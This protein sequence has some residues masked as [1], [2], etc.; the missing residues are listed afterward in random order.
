MFDPMEAENDQIIAPRKSVDIE[1]N[2]CE[3]AN[4][5]DCDVQVITRTWIV[6]FR[7]ISYGDNGKY[8]QTSYVVAIFKPLFHIFVI[9]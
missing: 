4:E 3:V 8:M 7:I 6:F 9:I 5:C 2:I 1:F